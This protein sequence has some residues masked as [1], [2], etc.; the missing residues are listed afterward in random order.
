MKPFMPQGQHVKGRYSDGSLRM[1]ADG[2]SAYHVLIVTALGNFTK[3]QRYGPGNDT[4]I[5]ISL[6][7]S[8][9]CEGLSRACLT[10]CKDSAI[11][12]FQCP[13]ANTSGNFLKHLCNV[14]LG[15]TGG[16]AASM[17]EQRL[18]LVLLCFSSQGAVEPELIVLSLIVHIPAKRIRFN[19]ADIRLTKLCSLNPTL[20]LLYEEY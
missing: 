16:D 7:T 19:N 1:S 2:P 5:N 11:E 4:T 8:C 12:A 14:D 6:R 9:D 20:D 15:E 10:I 17:Q 18:Y 13:K 3:D